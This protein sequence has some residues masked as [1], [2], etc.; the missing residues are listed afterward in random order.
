MSTGVRSD[1]VSFLEQEVL[2]RLTPEQ[3]FT[4]PALRW[5]KAEDKW[6]GGCPWHRSESGTSLTVS[7]GSLLWYCAGCHFGGGP[8]QYLW[9][10]RGGSGSPTG[11]DFVALVR[12]LATRAG[13]PF[14]ERE[15]SAAEIE[16]ARYREARRALLEA[17]T[18]HCQE[19]LSSP[20]GEA[21]RTYLRERRGL[22]DEDLETLRVGLSPSVSSLRRVLEAQGHAPGDVTA[23]GVLAPRLEGFFLIPWADEH[24]RPLTLYGR[25]PEKTPPLMQEL[26]AWREPRRRSQAEWKQLSPAEQ[27]RVPWEEPRIPKTLA[28]P[29]EGTKG[30]PL[31]FDR[32]RRAGHPDL[33]LV[34]GVFDAALLQARGE[35]QVIACVGAQL[36][37]AQ[38]ETLARHGV[39]SVTL[40]LDPDSA[41][42]SGIASCLRSL[43]TAGIP[44]F[45][46]P[47]LPDGLDPDELV[48]RDGLEAWRGHLRG[49]V[50]AYRYQ[51]EALIRKHRPGNEWSDRGRARALEEAV[52]L[53]ASFPADRGMEREGFFWPTLVRETGVDQETLEARV[54][55]F[56]SSSRTSRHGAAGIAAQADPLDGEGADGASAEAGAE[57]AAE[58]EQGT[59]DERRD[60]L[61]GLLATAET[62]SPGERPRLLAALA[63]EVFADPLEASTWAQRIKERKLAPKCAFLAE[64]AEARKR[65]QQEEQ[66]SLLLRARGTEEVGVVTAR[67]GAYLVQDGRICHEQGTQNGPMIKPLCNFDVRIT[68]QEIRDDGAGRTTLLSLEGSLQSGQLLPPITV[69]AERYKTMGWVTSSWGARP[70]VYAGQSTQDHLRAAIQLLHDDYPTRTVYG[71]TG[72]R[73]VEGEP[74]YLHA[75]GAIGR[76]GAV[77]G[78]EVSFGEGRLN[79]Y[80]LPPPPSGAALQEALRASLALLQVGPE[81]VTYPLLAAVYRAPLSEAL[82]ADFSLFL[83][84]ATGSQKSELSAL[85]QAH[86]GAKFQGRN[87]PGNWS[88]SANTLEKE[89]FQIKDAL[90]TVDDFAPG[91]AP[92]DVQR[93]HKEADRLF[94]GRGN[95]A[96]RGRMRADMSL[97]PEYYPR[98]MLLSSGEDVPK[99]ESAQARLVV[100]ELA[101]GDVDLERLTE[102]Q[103]HSRRGLYAAALAGYLQWLAPR[104]ETL[105]AS[106]QTRHEVLRTAFRQQGTGH[107]RTPDNMA[108]LMLGL[109]RLLRFAEESGAI[110]PDEGIAHWERAW[111]LFLGTAALQSAHLSSEEPTTRFLSLLNGVISS[112]QAHVATPDGIGHPENPDRW[113]WQSREVGSGPDLRREWQPQGERIGWVSDADLLLEPDAAYAAVHRL[114]RDQGSSV[115]IAARTL[116]KRLEEK[117]LLASREENLG[118]H[119]VRWKLGGVRKRVI[120]LRVSTLGT[121]TGPSG[122]NGPAA[123][124]QA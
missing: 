7:P 49:A 70:V 84:G 124:L 16:E 22:S 116:W 11:Q 28:L 10:L 80:A 34:E 9:R 48:L 105:P 98:G 14:P 69:S 47:Q 109:E 111:Q 63:G 73:V 17:V 19:T 107:D 15:L 122:P 1:L 43:K 4:D 45:V 32:A 8:I 74:I 119:T 58:E 112:G 23:A 91:G 100:L 24:G 65:R 95:R 60:R 115:P 97:R 44:A 51:A 61:E 25:W 104:L 90:F 21:A 50:H 71:H 30:S 86:Y 99:G 94:R 31:Y 88:S 89:A 33:V 12:E 53:A 77:E 42:E 81:A 39:R 38:V 56:Q 40:C 96:G 78:I 5:H 108:S 103:A 110:T 67:A 13:A 72:W 101:R 3:V 55:S 93:L 26:P 57:N 54:R 68:G 87:L 79:D 35:T 46:A 6:R 118:R 62:A 41:G 113:G 29:G 123:G 20:A 120:H 27:A 52:R 121:E 66:R 64:V 59:G 76:E 117:G 37:R 102:A 82:P 92:A 83:V 106:L 75:G 2:P 114:A 18:G 85:A 36:S